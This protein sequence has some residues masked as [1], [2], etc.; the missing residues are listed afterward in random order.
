MI[1]KIKAPFGVF[2]LSMSFMPSAVATGGEIDSDN[3][4]EQ[5]DRITVHGEAYR[6]TGT[7]T[8]LKPIEAPMSYEVYDAE[9]LKKRQVDSVNKAL[10]YVPGVTQIGRAHV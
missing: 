5:L 4:S 9:L 8:Q 7:K 6:S 2:L 10:R 1:A 3:P